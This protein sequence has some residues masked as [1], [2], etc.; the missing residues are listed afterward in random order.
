VRSK[1]FEALC[2]ST[3]KTYE[4]IKFRPYFSFLKD[5]ELLETESRMFY[6]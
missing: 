1:L 5:S 4:R 2:E 3:L 6:R